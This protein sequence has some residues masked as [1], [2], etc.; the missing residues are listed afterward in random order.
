MESFKF[1]QM[2]MGVLGTIFVVM[3]LSFLS[4]AIYHSDKPEQQGYAVEVAD[5][6]G[7]ESAQEP[8]G[9]AFEPISAMLASADIDA[10][11]KAAKRCAACHTFEQGG[12]NKV[13][14]ALYDIVNR[15]IAGTEGFSYSGALKEYGAEKTW[16]YEELNGFLWNP[17]KFIKGTS[18]GFAGLKKVDDRANIVAYLR[19]LSG[20]PAPL[21]AQ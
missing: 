10:G 15:Q 7:S 8:A 12:A 2:A 3:A 21:P 4:E 16:T 20:S 14:P 17:K 19:S 6:G 18:M 5:S 11:E 9:P 13:G 1:N